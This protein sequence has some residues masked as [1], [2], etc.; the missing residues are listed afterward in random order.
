[1]EALYERVLLDIR[2]NDISRAQSILRW[3][4][5]SMR[6]LSLEEVAECVSL[7]NSADILR[8]CTS[9]LV[10][11]FISESTGRELV[12]FAH[13]SVKDYLQSEKLRSSRLETSLYFVS[14]D[15]AHNHVAEKCRSYLLHSNTPTVHDQ[16]DSVQPLFSYA[17][18][19]WYTHIQAVKIPNDQTTALRHRAYELFKPESSRQFQNW[20]EIYT[21]NSDLETFDETCTQQLY[22]AI[23]LGFPEAAILLIREGFDANSHGGS[24]GTPLQTASYYGYTDVVCCL[25]EHGAEVYAKGKLCGTALY[26]ASSRGHEQ[27][28]RELL[29]N[30][31]VSTKSMSLGGNEQKTEKPCTVEHDPI[32]E[33]TYGTPLQAA[34]YQGY[35]EIVSH[36]LNSG[37]D[38]NVQGGL[39]GNALQAASASGRKD[40]VS[41]LLLK[42]DNVDV[43]GGLLGTP[44]QA[45]I[46]GGHTDI[47]D[48]LVAKGARYEAST[49][50]LWQEAFQRVRSQDQ[51]LIEYYED[52]LKRRLDIP[53]ELSADQKLLAA[54]IR[55]RSQ[56]SVK[57]A[58][59]VSEKTSVIIKGSP[60]MCKLDESHHHHRS[61]ADRLEAN[62]YLYMNL[63]PAGNTLIVSN[64]VFREPM[65]A[66]LAY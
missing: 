14:P 52:R 32:I 25:L 20:L 38:S 29:Q 27:I 8:I 19:F 49:G 37:A 35:S 63:I 51:V 58:F 30:R 56:Q 1:M 54:V 5:V 40:I 57:T 62:G 46:T 7:P 66:A 6:P 31:D 3:L 21:S 60:D 11:T 2:D 47:R 10:E 16:D 12:R 61:S 34:A 13:A 53:K 41:L 65:S 22:Y 48:M 42:V 9:T 44:L 33:G 4:A 64:S 15:L 36:L 23:I 45:A 18:L 26:A 39:F 55:I 28:V 43:R 50:Q 59:R 17:A 24:Q